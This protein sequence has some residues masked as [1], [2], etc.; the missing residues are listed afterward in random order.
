MIRI[1]LTDA[2]AES[3]KPWRGS[4]IYLERNLSNIFRW[5][6]LPFLTVILKFRSK[7]FILNQCQER[8]LCNLFKQICV[9]E[10]KKSRAIIKE[11]MSRHIVLALILLIVSKELTCQS[12]VEENEDGTEGSI[13]FKTPD[14]S[15]EISNN[16]WMPSELKCDSC[17]AI[18]YQV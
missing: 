7:A 17:R 2:S 18:A 15:D 12:V 6:F 4:K 10:L 9:L 16:P 8:F 3:Q 13:S 14:L 5:L 11:S 1:R